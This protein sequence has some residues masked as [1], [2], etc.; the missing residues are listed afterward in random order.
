MVKILYKPLAILF[1][2]L[3]GMIA[4]ALFKQAW[5]LLTGEEDAPDATDEDREW[6][7]ILPA[8]AVQGAVFAVVKAVLHRGSA[9][10]LRKVTGTWPA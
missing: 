6:R 7:Q 9:K 2:V 4:G 1:G 8:A 10:G 3:S 5:K